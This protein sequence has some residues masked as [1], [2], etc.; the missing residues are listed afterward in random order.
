MSH[1]LSCF[2][3]SAYKTSIEKY[4]YLDMQISDLDMLPISSINTD[5]PPRVKDTRQP[6][7]R[8]L[9]VHLLLASVLFE[10][11]AFYS[12]SSNLVVYLESKK[13]HWDYSYS[14]TAVQLFYGRCTYFKNSISFCLFSL[15]ATYIWTFLFAIISDMKLGR[16]KV[17]IIGFIIY[18]MG[19]TILTV[20]AKGTTNICEFNVTM[21]LTEPSI[22]EQRCAP[23]ILTG[24]MLT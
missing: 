3:N 1:F 18:L 6:Y 21:H 17:I 13:L 12:L 11:I 14:A 24:L 9:A 2:C 4:T 15:G 19:F 10:R 16:I 8:E 22:I 20:V 7:Q 5:I 23:A